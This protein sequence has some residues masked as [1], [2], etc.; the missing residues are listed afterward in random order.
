MRVL[1]ILV[2]LAAL[3]HA[4]SFLKSKTGYQG[5][6]TLPGFIGGSQPHLG[7]GI[8]GGR[9]FISQPNLG[10]GIGGGIGGGKPFIPQPNLG[11]GIGSTRPFPRP[12]Y[13]DYGSRNSCNRQ[14]PSTYGGR[15][16]CCRRWGSCCP[17]NY[18]G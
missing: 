9:P 4:E 17:T 15:G 11:G 5:V 3:A 12:Q 13:G 1:L 7:G 14:C 8:G 6:Q 10:G 2:S 16:I 18:K